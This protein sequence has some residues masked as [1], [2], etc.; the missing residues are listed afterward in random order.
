VHASE[1]CCSRERL[2]VIGGTKRSA[3]LPCV[4]ALARVYM[5]EGEKTSMLKLQLNAHARD[6][7]VA[8]WRGVAPRVHMP[9]VS[10]LDEE[11]AISSASS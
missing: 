1:Q 7:R 4:R 11:P 5:R 9:A 8:V 10:Y 2:R 3:F 6:G